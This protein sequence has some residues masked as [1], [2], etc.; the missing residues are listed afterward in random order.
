MNSIT[1]L[2]TTALLF[3][4]TPHVTSAPL[5]V[6]GQY[7]DPATG[8]CAQCPL[9]EQYSTGAVCSACAPGSMVSGTSCAVCA[10]GKFAAFKGSTS[11]Q[12]CP[13]GTGSTAGASACVRCN[14]AARLANGVTPCP[15][16]TTACTSCIAGGYNDGLKKRCTSCSAGKFSTMPQAVSPNTC[17][18]CT[19]GQTTLPTTTGATS[20]IQCNDTNIPTPRSA[21]YTKDDDTLVCAWK[22]NTGYTRFNYSETTYTAATYTALGY[23]TPQALAI[24]HNRNDFCCEPST[25]KVGMY[26]CGTSLPVCAPACTRSADGDSTQCAAIGNAHYIQ[27]EKYKFNR[28]DDWVC[29]DFFFLN[30][31]SGICTAQPICQMGWTYQRDQGQGLYVAQPSGSFTCVPCSQCIDGSET[32]TPCN[33]I[34]DTICRVCSSAE[35]SYQAA[36]CT[37]TVPFGF[38]PTRI[39]STG[40][41]VF[42]GRPSIF[43]DATPVQW[44]DIDFTQGFFLNSYTPCQPVASVALMFIGG[45]ETCNRLDLTFSTCASPICKTQ[46]KPWNGIEGWYKLLKTGECSKCIYDPTCTNT[47]YSDMTTCG[48]ATAPSCAACP[49]IPLPNSLGWI[50]PGRTPFPGPYA[51]DFVCRDGFAKGSNYSC[52]PCP[53]IPANSKITGGC[54]WACSLGFVQDSTACIACVGVPTGCSTGYYI[55][56][57]TSI[58][59]CARCLMCTNIVANAAYISSGQPNGPNTCG[60]QCLEGTFVSP[61]YGFDTYNN[62]VACDGCS[63]PQCTPGTTYLSPCSYLADAECTPCSECTTGSKVLTAC[64]PASNVT[65]IACNPSE[66]PINAKWMEQGCIK[67]ECEAGFV[68]EPNT[69]TCL[70]CKL[71]KDCIAS[72]SYEDDGGGT[73]CGRCVACDLFLLLPGQCFNGDGQCGVSYQCDAGMPT[74][75]MSQTSAAVVEMAGMDDSAA[76]VAAERPAD[77]VAVLAYASMAILTLDTIPTNSLIKNISAQLSSDCACEAKIMAITQN[78]ITAFCSPTCTLQTTDNNRRLLYAAQQ[79]TILDIVLL[80]RTQLTHI[81]RQPVC[82]GHV[83][84]G[85]QIYECRSITD[86]TF[87]HDQRKLVVYFKRTGTLWTKETVSSYSMGSFFI[88]LIVMLTLLA[89]FVLA[90]S[91]GAAV[92]YY[93]R[94]P[95]KEKDEDEETHPT[96]TQTARSHAFNRVPQFRPPVGYRGKGW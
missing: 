73:G 86:P 67:W 44:N 54:N 42:Q 11:C 83:V 24:F 22:C 84:T 47:Q 6:A 13:S 76:M 10:A 80:S 63:S 61:G 35:Y 78:N 40:I 20:C 62:P 38:S 33:G 88:I 87:V 14:P 34:N 29:D 68:R 57:A 30:K 23:S 94:V 90:G 37:G 64:T 53:N 9:P 46:C 85:W 12:A 4:S 79:L 74:A 1:F 92:V 58:S 17:S 8:S 27:M 52:I 82:S 16:C 36:P 31:T 26:M 51:C 49:T 75:Q 43:S 32:A 60:I 70:K 45:D 41:P 7:T 2:A 21:M 56:Y 65:C 39:R 3:L 71:P 19:A 96:N 18:P 77:S 95:T 59:Q 25:V 55:G 72:D 5:C 91:G 66:L 48:P 50:N 28:C 93:V 81:P 69:T 15:N 89:V